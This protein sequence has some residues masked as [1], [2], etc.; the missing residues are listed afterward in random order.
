MGDLTLEEQMARC[1]RLVLSEIETSPEIA[2]KRAWIC[3][4]I[5]K[6]NGMDITRL[7]SYIRRTEN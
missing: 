3:L 5:G 7:L 4:K 6:E 1:I 2:R